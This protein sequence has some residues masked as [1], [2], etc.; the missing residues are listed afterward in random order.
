MSVKTKTNLI[1]DLSI[2]AAFL[3]VASPSLTGMTIHEWLAL[4]LGAAVLAHLLFHWDWVVSVSKK[5]FKKLFHQSR[6]NYIVNIAFFVLATASMFSGLLISK[7]LLATLGISLNMD[8]SWETLHRM[9]SD[10]AIIALGLHFALHTKWLVFNTKRYLITPVT[11]RFLRP[12]SSSSGQL[13]VQ[14]VHTHDQ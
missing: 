13:A 10:W 14:P 12:A 4:A 9:T 6:L 7:S 8:R 3:V 11:K 5:F 1:L 2:F